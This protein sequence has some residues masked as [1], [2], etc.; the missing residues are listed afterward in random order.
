MTVNPEVLQ[1]VPSLGIA[2]PLGV[3]HVAETARDLD[4]QALR[5]EEEVD[6]CDV[7]PRAVSLHRLGG[8]SSMA[9]VANEAKERSLQRRVPAC[10]GEDPIDQPA[11]P[12]SRA[13]EGRQA[14]GE[15]D[16]MRQ[17]ESDGAVERGFDAGAA[18]SSVCEI[19][20]GPS[21]RRGSKAVDG[22]EVARRDHR[23]RVNRPRQSCRMTASLDREFDGVG[24]GAVESMERRSR[25]VADPTPRAEAEQ[26][27][28]EPLPVG[29]GCSGQSVH[30]GCH[31]GEPGRLDP[32]ANLLVGEAG[33]P[34]GRQSATTPS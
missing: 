28:A 26:T 23:C 8:G 19:D 1:F 24:V 12:S 33:R 6:P 20:H 22:H 13:A 34:R 32:V 16:R 7:S 29:V 5:L 4:D 27:D 3:R 15:D 18:G 25:F 14:L 30:T 11:P 31:L 21:R 10:V 2:C 9:G 17:A